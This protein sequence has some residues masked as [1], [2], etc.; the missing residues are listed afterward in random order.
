MLLAVVGSP[1][2]DCKNLFV[3]SDWRPINKFIV[4]GGL[5]SLLEH[6]QSLT[7]GVRQLLTELLPRVLP[8]VKVITKMRKL[9]ALWERVQRRGPGLIDRVTSLALVVRA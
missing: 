5:Q 9:L 6:N 4:D 3:C 7:W 2:T 1:P 8:C